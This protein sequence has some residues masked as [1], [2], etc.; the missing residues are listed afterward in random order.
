M[1][2][3]NQITTLE[4]E[5][6]GLPGWLRWA[7]AHTVTCAALAAASVAAGPHPAAGGSLPGGQLLLTALFCVLHGLTIVLQRR[8]S[9]LQLLLGAA[10]LPA[11]PIFLLVTPFSLG[12]WPLGSWIT[13]LMTF[14]VAGALA[15]FP[16]LSA[17]DADGNRHRDRLGASALTWGLTALA[18][19]MLSPVMQR[20]IHGELAAA[21]VSGTLS[22]AAGGLGGSWLATGAWGVA[23]PPAVPRHLLRDYLVSAAGWL[24]G[25]ALLGAA[26]ALTLVVPAQLLD[27]NEPYTFWLWIV[28]LLPFVGGAAMIGMGGGLLL[29]WLRGE[30]RASS[31]RR[32][33][34]G[35]WGALLPGLLFSVG[36]VIFFGYGYPVIAAIG[37]GGCIGLGA[38]IGHERVGTPGADRTP[39]WPLALALASG[40]AWGLAIWLRAGAGRDIGAVLQAFVPGGITAM[41]IPGALAGACG[42]VW[43][44]PVLLLAV[45]GGW[46]P[47]QRLQEPATE[48]AALKEV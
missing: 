26:V 16:M 14:A 17:T 13:R 19:S 42:A 33:H 34:M 46:S 25:C 32:A 21:I 43:S 27:Y 36:P 20:V 38:G 6:S 5:R 31:R 3:L 39:W 23:T 40:G 28:T 7:S 24:A 45:P 12:T 48:S 8:G 37:A 29:A 4:D 44:L 30:G 47:H 10:T 35:W 15:A 1:T 41:L 2:A 18:D 22:G 9:A 11:L